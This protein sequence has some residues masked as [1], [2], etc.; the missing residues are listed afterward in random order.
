MSVEQTY[1]EIM[2]GR[3]EPNVMWILGRTLKALAIEIGKPVTQDADANPIVDDEL[4]RVTA[5]GI[6]LVP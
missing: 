2:F 5:E 3:E 6:Y 1:N 4:Y